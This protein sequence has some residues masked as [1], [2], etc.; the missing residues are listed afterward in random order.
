MDW[1]VEGLIPSGGIVFI[2]SHQ[3]QTNSGAHLPP[4]GYQSAPPLEE[5]FRGVKLVNHLNLVSRLRMSGA[6]S[7]LPIR[8]HGMVFI[9]AGTILPLLVS[10]V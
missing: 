6:I 9:C 1:T 10:H 4:D 7:P 3:A 8:F 2:G 5:R